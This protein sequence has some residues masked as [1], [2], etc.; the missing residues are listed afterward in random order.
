M[1]RNHL[2]S[3]A[4]TIPQ[5]DPFKGVRASAGACL[6]AMRGID[7]QIAV[8]DA[9]LARIGQLQREAR[10]SAEPEGTA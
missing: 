7:E 4:S 1:S 3:G 2:L 5:S 6:D 8:A 10:A 9:L